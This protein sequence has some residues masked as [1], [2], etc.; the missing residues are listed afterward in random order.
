MRYW[1]ECLSEPYNKIQIMMIEPL[2]CGLTSLPNPSISESLEDSYYNLIDPLILS[3]LRVADSK[4]PIL[5]HHS[6]GVAGTLATAAGSLGMHNMTSGSNG[7]P[8]INTTM[9][10]SDTKQCRLNSLSIVNSSD[11]E[12]YNSSG[13]TTTRSSI[14]LSGGGVSTGNLDSDNLSSTKD[15][16]GSSQR[17]RRAAVLEEGRV[18]KKLK[19][20]GQLVD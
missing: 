15:G 1:C 10:K 20:K 5:P 2:P 18:L 12:Q 14:A 19:I 4:R 9:E 8:P 3:A 6:L 7:I 13:L 16:I 11:N 17:R